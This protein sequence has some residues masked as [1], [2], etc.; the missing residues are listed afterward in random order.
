MIEH[1]PRYD[2]SNQAPVYWNTTHAIN[3]TLR[4]HFAGQVLCGYF[5]NNHK[6]ELMGL[7]LFD[8]EVRNT[9]ANH[10]YEIADAMLEARKNE[11]R[12]P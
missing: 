3:M 10:A 5:A 4:D 6:D 1:D 9:I 7:G 2:F 12:N 8:S 11:V